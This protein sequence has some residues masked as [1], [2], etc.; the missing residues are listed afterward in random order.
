MQIQAGSGEGDARRIYA[1]TDWALQPLRG[2]SISYRPGTS[3]L[4]RRLAFTL[5]VAVM[6]G[7]A[8]AYEER[9]HASSRLAKPSPE[10]QRETR[11]I[12][13][14]LREDEA[15]LRETM[16]DE[17]WAKYQHTLADTRAGRED[18]IEDAKKRSAS[19]MRRAGQVSLIVFGLLAGFGILAPLSCL[20]QRIVV[21]RDP[22]NNLVVRSLVLLPKTT[23]FPIDGFRCATV[24]AQEVRTSRR[25]GNRPVGWRWRVVLANDTGGV[26]F[27]PD[28]Q[29]HRPG[30]D[31]VSPRTAHFLQR[32]KL[33]TGLLCTKPQQVEWHSGRAG[34]YRT[35]RTLVTTS[36]PVVERHVYRSPDEMPSHLRRRAEEMVTKARER[37]I[38]SVT[39]EQIMIRDSDG[40]AHT[41]NSV[42]EMPPDVR[43]RYEEMRRRFPSQ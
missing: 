1:F 10:L 11:Q 39:R 18:R 13:K 21:E 38:S 23:A 28:Q 30:P 16:T 35:G 7:G 4:L 25:T 3:T 6:I 27:W 42:E 36:E 43:A 34:A 32:L 22:R 15:R 40:N 37:G 41:Y 24:L 20:W 14:R 26:E 29:K 12:E 8:Y 17:Q 31:T 33:L 5:L 2:D 19:F 9:M